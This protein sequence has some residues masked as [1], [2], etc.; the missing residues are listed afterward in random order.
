MPRTPTAYVRPELLVW[1]RESI[2]YSPEEAAAKLRQPLARLMAWESGGAR[3]TIAQLRT[4]AKVYKRPLAVFYLSA[5]PQAFQ[6][7]RDFR[8]LPSDE[9]EGAYSPQLHLAIRTARSRREV[10][11]DLLREIGDE[12]SLPTVPG[13]RAENVEDL[14]KAARELLGVTLGE[15]Q[16]WRDK[17]KALRGWI[18]ALED[19]GVLVFQ[20]SGVDLAEMRGFSITDSPLA[21]IVANAKDSPRGR[22]FTLMHEFAH[23]LLK[24]GGICDLRESEGSYLSPERRTEVFCNQVAAEVL[25]P[26]DSLLSDI[27]GIERRQGG[28]WSDDD[29]A[30]LSTLY[31]VSGE[32]IL[33]RLLTL[34]LTTRKFYRQKRAEHLEAYARRSVREGRPSYHRIRVRDLGRAYLGIVLDAYHREAINSADL[35]EYLGIRLKHVPRL[36]QEAFGAI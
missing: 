32:V 8:R 12:P 26:T 36:E 19:V 33:R 30:M 9:E 34:G 28:A 1:A 20:T 14:A 13:N 35:S 23:I 21:V 22:V 31:S 16:K 29:V 5:P 7:M 24:E 18:T 4:A 17:Y 3:P 11:L 6:A 2:G 15:Q 25:V 10:A 27:E